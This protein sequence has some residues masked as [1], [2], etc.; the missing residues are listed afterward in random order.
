MSTALPVTDRTR[1]IVR[2]IYEAAD[3]GALDQLGAYFSG[4][5]VMTQPAGSPM[6]GQW[7]GAEADA[8]MGRLFV[9]CGFRKITVRE[10]LSE[11][12]P[13]VV[14][15]VDVEG[16][17]KDGSRG[18]CRPPNCSGLRTARSLTSA[19]ST[20]TSSSSAGQPGSTGFRSSRD[21]S[22]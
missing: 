5:Y 12:P 10:V 20:G 7:S 1:E 3:R 16:V 19:P 2:A 8:A 17:A 18:R 15:M 14:G 21:C 4:D 9:T 13:R 11:G 22:R 6:P